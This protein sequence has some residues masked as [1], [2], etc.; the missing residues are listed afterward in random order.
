[1]GLDSHF[2]YSQFCFFIQIFLLVFDV[3]ITAYSQVSGK[4]N[5]CNSSQSLHQLAPV[6]LENQHE[7]EHVTN[8]PVILLSYT[9]PQI[10]PYFILPTKP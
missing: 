4:Y 8:S 10:A 6:R 1:M 5:P 9:I 7:G 3:L 2:A